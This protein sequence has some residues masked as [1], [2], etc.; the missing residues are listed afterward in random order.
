MGMQVDYWKEMKYDI[1]CDFFLSVQI[2]LF[3]VK[4]DFVVSV[5]NIVFEIVNIRVSIGFDCR[6]FCIVC[7][8]KYS[9]MFKIEE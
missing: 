2:S 4:Y 8:F 6:V 9:S 5:V 1:G 7:L 3:V